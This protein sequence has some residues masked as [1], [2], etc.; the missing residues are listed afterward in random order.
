[1][2]GG[3]P[4]HMSDSSSDHKRKRPERRAASKQAP[5]FRKR[6][7]QEEGLW[8]LDEKWQEENDSGTVSDQDPQETEAAPVAQE[9]AAVPEETPAAPEMK[10]AASPPDSE[11]TVIRVEPSYSRRR[12]TRNKRR[13]KEP[14]ET[15]QSNSEVAGTS[16]PVADVVTPESEELSPP[17]A[18]PV[19]LGLTEDEVW[20]DFLSD[21]E[22]ARKESSPPEEVAQ[23]ELP[24][25]DEAPAIQ[26][27]AEPEPDKNDQLDLVE[28]VTSENIESEPTAPE[29][30]PIE[31]SNAELF[32]ENPAEQNGTDS[33]TPRTEENFSLSFPVLS[34]FEL[35]A[36][37]LFFACLLSGGIWA[38]QVFRTEVQA[39]PNPYLQPDLPAKGNWAT[40]ASADTF[41]RAPVTEGE[42]ADPVRQ[43]VTLI[44]VI[45][46]KLGE[47]ASPRGAIRVIFYNDKGIIAGDTVTHRFDNHQ[48]SLSGSSERAFAATTG[49][50]NFGDQEA[51]RAHLVKPW[52]IRVYEGPDENA[53]SAEYR[54]LFTAPISTYIQ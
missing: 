8:N 18:A 30:T 38:L 27:H 32:D 17:R 34:R 33:A 25:E 37:F 44:P 3:C 28:A 52:T 53:P 49:F 46:I 11:E 39:Q 48:F 16:T 54:L 31:S 9:A 15:E 41:W 29:P 6:A 24:A 4:S 36:S 51:Y 1:M 20:A 43:D 2:R 22:L 12:L 7:P 21:E 35:V 23:S 14:Q 19:G 26:L 42:N 10:D 13:S 45:R 5:S 47:C 40:V 50:T